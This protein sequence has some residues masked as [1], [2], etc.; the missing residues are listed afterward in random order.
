[1]SPISSISTYVIGSLFLIYRRYVSPFPVYIEIFASDCD[2]Q[3]LSAIDSRTIQNHSIL[4]RFCEEKSLSQAV[5]GWLNLLVGSLLF[6][7]H[8]SIHA[9]LPGSLISLQDRD[10]TVHSI[11]KSSLGPLACGISRSVSSFPGIRGE[12]EL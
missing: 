4:V 10:L 3:N 8:V 5:S 1:M 11:P 6:P 2:A 7:S 9:Q 12:S